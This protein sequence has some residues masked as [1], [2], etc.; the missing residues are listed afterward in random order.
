[1]ACALAPVPDGVAEALLAVGSVIGDFSLDLA[2]CPQSVPETAIATVKVSSANLARV[3]KVDSNE[4]IAK[5]ACGGSKNAS[6][7]KA[8]GEFARRNQRR[9]LRLLEW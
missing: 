4:Y 6:N 5:E 9:A 2:S 7:G 8:Q 1:V 3:R